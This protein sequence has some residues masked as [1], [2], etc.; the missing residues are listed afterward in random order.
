MPCSRDFLPSFSKFFSLP[1]R[2]VRRRVFFLNLKSCSSS[3]VFNSLSLSTTSFFS[4]S[5]PPHPSLIFSF[6]LKSKYSHLKTKSSNLSHNSS[7]RLK[8]IN[9]F[10]LN[11]RSLG[12][13]SIHV[14]N[15]FFDS[16]LDF[17]ALSETWHESAFFPYLISA[18][19][20]SYPFL[21][22]A[23]ALQNPLSTSFSTYGGNCLF[24][25]PLFPPPRFLVLVSNLLNPLSLS[26]NMVLSPCLLLLFIDLLL[27]S[28]FIY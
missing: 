16:N 1:S 24:T 14:F 27:L 25:N 20:P 28:L 26:L 22:L 3:S 10:F 13:K 21:E 7:K 2:T 9:I 19:S 18:C 11:I 23:R 6:P 5:R 17:L 4:S 15:L 12:N 8:S